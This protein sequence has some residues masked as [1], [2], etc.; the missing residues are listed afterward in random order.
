[1]K[2]NKFLLKYVFTLW[3]M[4]LLLLICIFYMNIQRQKNYDKIFDK[5]EVESKKIHNEK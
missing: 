5:Y 4:C 2:N 1:M 3:I